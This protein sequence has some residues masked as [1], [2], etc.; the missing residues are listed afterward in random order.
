MK[1]KKRVGDSTI[2]V[3]TGTFKDGSDRLEL[4]SWNNA[5]PAYMAEGMQPVDRPKLGRPAKNPSPAPPISS[6]SDSLLKPTPK[7]TLA[8]PVSKQKPSA[9]STHRMVLRSR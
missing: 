4:H 1:L 6:E 3:K 2:E 9:P 7:T 8:K 5:K